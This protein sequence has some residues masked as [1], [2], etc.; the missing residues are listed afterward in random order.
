MKRREFIAALG[1][2]AAS[3]ALRP[4]SAR[5]QRPAMPVIGVLH[6]G[7]PPG[8]IS[9][10]VNALQK[11]INA[12]HDGLKEAGYVEGQNVAIEFRWANSDYARLSALADDLVRRRVTLI[13]A[14]GG[15]GAVEAARA[16]TSTIPIVSANGFDL[17]KHGFAA[18]LNRPGG[19]VTGVT[20]LADD[21]IGKQVALLHELLPAANSFAF[22]SVGPKDRAP[23]NMESDALSAANAI[24]LRAFLVR[25]AFEVAFATLVER[26]ASGI[27][28]GDYL[29]IAHNA[30][31]VVALAAKHRIP[32]IYPGSEYVRAGGLMSYGSDLTLLRKVTVQYVV[33]ILKG[34]KPADL[35]IQQATHFE[36]AINLQTASALGLTIPETLLATTD[37][38][39]Q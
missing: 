9:A 30:D 12:L 26:H 5:A 35:P 14:A 11:G 16:A 20:A 3:S 39:I 17:V 34:A 33:R 29:E 18:S 28:V 10:D 38:V 8:S 6:S 32:A 4:I 21:L 27:V 37:E 19:N 15:I 1:S 13:I 7:S 25:D 22:L 36:L 2:A 23:D 31:K 24:G